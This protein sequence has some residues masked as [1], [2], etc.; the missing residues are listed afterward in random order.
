MRRLPIYI[1]VDTSSSMKGEPIESVKKGLGE[2]LSS[3]RMEPYCLE[4][5][6]LSIITYDKEA[7][8]IL[9]LTDLEN[10]QLPDIVCSNAICSD[11]EQAINVLCECIDR[12][13]IPS[14][15][16]VKGDWKPKILFI[17]NG[18]VIN[19]NA[20]KRLKKYQIGRIATY[21][22]SFED[23]VDLLTKLDEISDF[24]R[25]I[26]I[27]EEPCCIGNRMG[28]NFYH[29]ELPPPPEVFIVL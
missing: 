3:L 17:S 16:D 15:K 29:I 2:I 18:R 28:E 1:L 27:W 13:I 8:Q 10:L 25:I 22:F 21:K 11:I 4:T 19:N 7:R 24:V 14:N 5:A 20:I 9:P 12:D 23:N 6:Y 26:G